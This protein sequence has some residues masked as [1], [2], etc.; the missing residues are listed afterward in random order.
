MYYKT[1][2]KGVIC[3]KNNSKKIINVKVNG[4]LVAEN[5]RIH[6][7]HL[8]FDCPL[9]AT[10]SCPKILT[11]GTE[12][13]MNY[14]F[15]TEGKQVLIIKENIK[16]SYFDEPYKEVIRDSLIVTKC[17]RYDNAMKNTRKN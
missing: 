16:D 7:A 17:K 3:V 12:P 13:I 6:G 14:P 8:C 1:Q 10:L 15:I 2:K 9:D 11:C 4:K 5:T